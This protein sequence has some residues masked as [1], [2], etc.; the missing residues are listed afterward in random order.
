VAAVFKSILIAAALMLVGFGAADAVWAEP[1]SPNRVIPDPLVKHIPTTMGA[2]LPGAEKSAVVRSAKA[3]VVSA[4]VVRGSLKER[5]S[6]FVGSCGNVWKRQ[7][8][9]T[10]RPC[11]ALSEHYGIDVRRKLVPARLSRPQYPQQYTTGYVPASGEQST[12]ANVGQIGD[13]WV[14]MNRST[15]P[16]GGQESQTKVAPR[17]VS[18]E[19][20]K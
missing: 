19:N 4:K 16:A 15:M 13:F 14:G 11:P 1:V 17:T 8:A 6:R 2:L 3:A 10:T 5:P 9:A 20:A 7:Y 12:G 18:G